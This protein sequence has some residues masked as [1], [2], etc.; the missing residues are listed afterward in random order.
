MDACRAATQRPLCR[1]ELLLER[2]ETTVRKSS[3]VEASPGLTPAY[4]RLEFA[5]AFARLGDRPRAEDLMAAARVELDPQRV[6]EALAHK[7]TPTSGPDEAQ[8]A[9]LKSLERYKVDRLR[10]IS[11]IKIVREYTAL[12]L[13][14]TKLVEAPAR[15]DVTL[16]GLGQSKSIVIKIVRDR[17]GL[18]LAQT[19]QLA[20]LHAAG[21]K[22]SIIP[23]P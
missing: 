5:W 19:N 23:S 2:I 9:A 18:G 8:L 6:T 21:T 7:L 3:A 11:L 22:A 16:E 20:D 12:G 13:K 14:D 15:F 4:V 17:T 10:G 1:L